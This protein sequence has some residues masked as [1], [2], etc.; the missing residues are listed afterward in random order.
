MIET[1]IEELDVDELM[2]KIRAEVRKRKSRAEMSGQIP[3]GPFLRA[4]S[5]NRVN[6]G[7]SNS[8][9]HQPL[10]PFQNKPDGY[11]MDDFL[12]YHHR[13]FVINAYQG[14][15][16]RSPDSDGF[17]HFLKDLQSAKMTKAEVLGR[18]HFSPEGRS[19]KVKVKGLPVHFGIQL[20]FRIPVLGYLFRLVV[21]IFNLP[22]LFR[23]LQKLEA[24][25]AVQ[26]M[27]QRNQT[28]DIRNW[29]QELSDLQQQTE[30]DLARK[31]DKKD[32][33]RLVEEKADCSDI[34]N[35]RALL[36]RHDPS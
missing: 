3:S 29:F 31:A 21:G 1:T 17:D 8:G 6:P 36:E 16:K 15:L 12:K 24:S 4:R 30:K 34:G 26:L 13:D 27:D 18:L 35:A 9:I 19:T 28:G 20:L 7:L 33:D 25:T 11:R 14:I 10:E 5:A 22:T 32:L 23:N 2:K